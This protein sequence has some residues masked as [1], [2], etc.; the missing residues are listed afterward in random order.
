MIIR[1]ARIYNPPRHKKHK[2]SGA[3]N[4]SH[5]WKRSSISPACTCIPFK[6]RDLVVPPL[7]NAGAGTG[8]ACVRP[9]GANKRG[10]YESCGACE[11]TEADVLPSLECA[12][13]SAAAVRRAIGDG[14]ALRSAGCDARSLRRRSSD[15]LS[16]SE[17]LLCRN[18]SLDFSL[19]SLFIFSSVAG[20]TLDTYLRLCSLLKG[21]EMIQFAPTLRHLVQG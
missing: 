10:E 14:W 1:S 17:S 11:D 2:T 16:S 4:S 13:I 18:I 5:I 20:C 15:S 7:S 3:Q 12:P 9:F 8:V 21:S 19:E 6:L